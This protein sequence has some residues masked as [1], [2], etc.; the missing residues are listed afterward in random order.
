MLRRR[1]NHDVH[2]LLLATLVLVGGYAVLRAFQPLPS[3]HGWGLALGI[4]GMILMIGAQTLYTWR[5]RR[6]QRPP[7]ALYHWLRAH[8][9]MGLL[10]GICVLLHGGGRFA[11]IAGVAA[12]MTAMILI[13]G[14]VGRYLYTALDRNTNDWQLNHLALQRRVHALSKSLGPRLGSLADFLRELDEMATPPTG[15]RLYATRIWAP[16]R[17]K[18]LLQARLARQTDCPAALRRELN[19][20]FQAKYELRLEWE[21]LLALRQLFSWWYLAHVP[22]SWIMLTLA[23]IHVVGVWFYWVK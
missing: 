17:A 12:A 5:K 21:S 16:W 7:G 18:R 9:A 3:G 20:L 13:S 22:L 11:G 4:A 19:E 1:T 23:V 8:V 15:W 14:L 10:G 6:T 2:Y